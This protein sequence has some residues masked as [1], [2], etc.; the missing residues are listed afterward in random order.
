MSTMPL[1]RGTRGSVFWPFCRAV[2]SVTVNA[3][4]SFANLEHWACF[5]MSEIFMAGLRDFRGLFWELYRLRGGRILLGPGE[6]GVRTNETRRTDFRD[7]HVDWAGAGG[8]A[9][10]TRAS[11]PRTFAGR[12]TA[13]ATRRRTNAGTDSSGTTQNINLWR[14]ETEPG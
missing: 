4:G 9:N 3:L 1:P 10:V 6:L 5:N 8:A 11:A 13:A 7:R 12:D 14:M 2:R